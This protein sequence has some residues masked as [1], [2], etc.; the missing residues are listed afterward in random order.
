MRQSVLIHDI[1]KMK[2]QIYKFMNS[3][4]FVKTRELFKTSLLLY[5]YFENSLAFSFWRLWKTFWNTLSSWI[6]ELVVLCFFD[7]MNRLLETSSILFPK[8]FWSFTTVQINCFSDISL[9]FEKFIL[10]FFSQL[11]LEVSSIWCFQEIR[12][13]VIFD[14]V[15]NLL[16]PPTHHVSK[17]KH[18]AKPTHPLFWLRNSWMVPY[19]LAKKN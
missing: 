18:L 5:Y 14:Y 2:P 3:K 19:Y 17:R 13:S 15:S 6:R 7:V 4:C 1:Q 16:N 10:D 9:E 8:L 11:F 12:F